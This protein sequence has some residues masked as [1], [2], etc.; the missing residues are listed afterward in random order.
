MVKLFFDGRNGVLGVRVA[1]PD[2]V[3][4]GHDGVPIR[5]QQQVRRCPLQEPVERRRRREHSRAKSLAV[6]EVLQGSSKL[7]S[8]ILVYEKQVIVKGIDN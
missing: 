8:E 5:L 6:S 7:C 3:A 2:G 4:D 1:G